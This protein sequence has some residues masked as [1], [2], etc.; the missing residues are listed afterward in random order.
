MAYAKKKLKVKRPKK[1]SYKKGGKFYHLNHRKPL[2]E[3]GGDINAPDPRPDNYKTGNKKFDSS[4]F[5]NALSTGATTLGNVITAGAEQ[6][7]G[8]L[9]KATFTGGEVVKGTGL[10][11]QLG[12]SLGPVGAAIGGA[13]GAVGGGIY[14]AITADERNAKVAANLRA[15]GERERQRQQDRA[16]TILATYPTSGVIG[17]EYYQKYGGKI[18]MPNGGKTKV[19]PNN[20]QPLGA[21]QELSTFDVVQIGTDKQPVQQ[22]T[23][24]MIRYGGGGDVTI[25]KNSE[26]KLVAVPINKKPTDMKTTL[27][28]GGKLPYNLGGKLPYQNGGQMQVPP[29]LNGNGQLTPTS[30]NT[31]LA[32]GASH[33]QG[34]I[35]L[36]NAEIEGGE[37]MRDEG[38]GTMDVY[39]DKLYYKPGVTYADQAD[40]ISKQK[41]KLEERLSSSSV[42]ARNTAQRRIENLDKDLQRLHEDQESLK[43]RKGINSQDKKLA[44]GGEYKRSYATPLEKALPYADNIVN[45]MLTQQTPEI[46]KPIYD[47]AMPM[48]T[49]VNVRPQIIEGQRQLSNLQNVLE[50]NTGSGTDF[51]S[52]VIAANLANIGNTNQLL[53]QKENAETQLINKAR[54]NQQLV[55]SANVAKENQYNIQKMHRVDDIHGRISKNVANLSTDAQMQIAQQNQYERDLAELDLLKLRYK[56]TGIWDR[57]IEGTFEEYLKGNKSGKEFVNAMG[58]LGKEAKNLAE[59]I[60][61]QG[62]RLKT[63]RKAKSKEAERIENQEQEVIKQSILLGQETL[64]PGFGNR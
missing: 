61:K 16:Q 59:K 38:N 4:G 56:E 10:G 14:G 35:E 36:P 48:K 43:S 21:D 17:N 5:V 57:N 50:R 12:S 62:K 15:Q 44:E 26:G 1:L 58:K 34:G 25:I 53:S 18:K 37:V 13:L 40:R 60:V 32:E 20:T 45:A 33:A 28:N 30:D 54:M 29:V 2:L 49:T 23:G 27:R 52:N 24:S 19:K 22:E 55:D 6:K 46:P 47:E 9:D 39:S 31:V 41:G 64:L 63:K 7:D 42:F 51:R 11:L 3:N 8:T